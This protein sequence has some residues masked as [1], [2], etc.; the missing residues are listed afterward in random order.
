[1]P[2]QAQQLE[3][4]RAGLSAREAEDVAR[5]FG[6]L[7]AHAEHRIESGQG[8][9]EDDGEPRVAAPTE[10]TSRLGLN[11][12]P[13]DHS[14]FAHSPPA[15][16]EAH[17]AR[18]VRLLPLPDSPTMASDAALLERERHVGDRLDRRTVATQ[19]DVRCSTSAGRSLGPQDVGQAVAE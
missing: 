9:L 14:T 13:H 3:C 1:M 11:L 16:Q 19:L 17:I 6:D 4:A 18:S 10:V 5:R 12:S 2:D 7:G 15:R 8:V